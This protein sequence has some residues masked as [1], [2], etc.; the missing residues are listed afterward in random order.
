MG[1]NVKLV[2]GIVTISGEKTY[3]GP[4]QM[5]YG[6]GFGFVVEEPYNWST[7]E[8]DPNN[9]LK[10]D[11]NEEFTESMKKE[12]IDLLEETKDMLNEFPDTFINKSSVEMLTEF[13]DKTRVY[14]EDGNQYTKNVSK[15][16]SSTSKS[17]NVVQMTRS[18]RSKKKKLKKYANQD[19]EEMNLAKRV[20]GIKL[21]EP[22]IEVEEKEV[23]PKP[24]F[25]KVP[26]ATKQLPEFD[27][28]LITYIHPNPETETKI[29]FSIPVC[30]PFNALQK[31]KY[32]LK[33]VSGKDKKGKT[34]KTLLN[35]FLLEK[36][37]EQNEQ[38]KREKLLIS[39]VA[40]SQI[41]LGLFNKMKIS[42]EK[43]SKSKSNKKVTKK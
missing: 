33:L 17:S 42:G 30:A 22:K 13:V 8:I 25:K 36:N 38:I 34:A 16:K 10:S 26:S 21:E 14:K 39:Q 43:A 15:Q 35:H 40:E 19:E 29:L 3:S 6:F 9:L 7:N 32:K 4:V 23:K 2:D 1:K 11:S 27:Y 41:I 20:L 28:N 24:I 18:E 37:E 5:I 12:E 31:F